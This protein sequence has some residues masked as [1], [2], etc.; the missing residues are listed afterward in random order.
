VQDPKPLAC[1]TLEG[2]EM[3]A[4]AQR[5]ERDA[6]CEC[7]APASTESVP[8]N[9]RDAES[10]EMRVRGDGQRFCYTASTCAGRDTLSVGGVDDCK[11][12]L[13]QFEYKG[14]F[15]PRKVADANMHND[16]KCV[17]RTDCDTATVYDA[18][19]ADHT[20]NGSPSWCFT[21]G[22]CPDAQGNI[23]EV[24]TLTC[25]P[26]LNWAFQ[27]QGAHVEETRLVNV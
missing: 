3:L 13:W 10:N 15:G 6:A 18:K 20:N 1:P 11:G 12:L 7:I 25:R 22:E 9:C 5:D 24:T 8:A 27:Y 21:A 19:L 2:A 26:G 17:A 4:V 16:C 23:N 14:A